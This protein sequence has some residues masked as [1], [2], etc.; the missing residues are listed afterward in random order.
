M[1]QVATPVVGLMSSG[2][3][4]TDL[5]SQLSSHTAVPQIN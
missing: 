1:V 4:E 5:M 2:V 3:F